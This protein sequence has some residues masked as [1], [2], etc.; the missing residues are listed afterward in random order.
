MSDSMISRGLHWFVIL[1]WLYAS[2]A[3]GQQLQF[4]VATV[5]PAAPNDIASGT[6][7]TLSPGRLEFHNVTLR[8]MIYWAYGSGLSTAM[9]VAGGPAWMNRDRYSIEAVTQSNSTDRDFR[10]MLRALLEERFALKTHGETRE[11]DVYALA[12]DRADGKLGPKVKPWS[13]TCASGKAPRPAGDPTIPRCTGAFRPPG[14]VLE[15]VT[16]VPLAEMLSTQRRLLGRIVQDRTALAGPYNIEFEF[17]F[18]TA[19]QPDYAGPSIFTAVKEQL[20]LKL[21]AS[22]GPLQVIVVESANAPGAN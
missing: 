5:K 6:T 18:N 7:P 17:D 10:T 22:K 19:N 16:M 20:G 2:A 9:S 13:E 12:P 8:T 4:D 15:G 21:V 14:L 1:C 11:I 3:F